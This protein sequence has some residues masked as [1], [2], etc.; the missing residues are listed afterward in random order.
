MSAASEYNMENNLPSVID[1][2]PCDVII[3]YVYKP[4]LINHP[5]L[6]VLFQL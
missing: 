2:Y 3:Q 6:Y 5:I 1:A 4:T